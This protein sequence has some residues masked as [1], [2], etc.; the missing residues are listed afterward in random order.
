MFEAANG[1][2]AVNIAA[3]MAFSFIPMDLDMHVLNG[4]E[5]AREL[6]SRP[7][8]KDVPIIVFSANCFSADE[9]LVGFPDMHEQ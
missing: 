4:C 3:R 1:Q 5:T 8:T 2:E 9:K 7:G 6:L